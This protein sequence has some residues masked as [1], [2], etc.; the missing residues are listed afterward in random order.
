MEKQHPVFLFQFGCFSSNLFAIEDKFSNRSCCYCVYTRKRFIPISNIL[1]SLF[2]F[3]IFSSFFWFSVF[4][5]TN[6]YF[7][8][9]I[10]IMKKKPSLYINMTFNDFSQRMVAFALKQTSSTLVR[11]KKPKKVVF[12]NGKLFPILSEFQNHSSQRYT[13]PLPPLGT[14]FSFIE[15]CFDRSVHFHCW[16][17]SSKQKLHSI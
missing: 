8:W 16:P 10:F 17:P 12:W 14:L 2:I 6:F 1:V 4:Y 11:N 15:L 7:T 5:F 9:H 3:F 13:F